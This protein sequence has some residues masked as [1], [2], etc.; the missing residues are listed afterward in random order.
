MSVRETL[1]LALCSQKT[2]KND[3][4]TIDPMAGF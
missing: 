1:I 4:E 3:Y 2:E